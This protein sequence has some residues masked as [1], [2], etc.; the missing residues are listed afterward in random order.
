MLKYHNLPLLADNSDN[1]DL[2]FQYYKSHFFD[3][4][5][6]SDDRLIRTPVFHS[7]INTY[8]ENLTAK[9]PDSIIVSCDYLIEKSREQIQTYSNMLFHI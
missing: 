6:F 5:D 1:K 9:I 4:F 8:L 7:K 2:Q 3:N